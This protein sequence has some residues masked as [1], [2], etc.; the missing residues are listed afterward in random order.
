MARD[1]KQRL[2]FFIRVCM[3]IVILIAA[4]IVYPI[5]I[6]G[7]SCKPKP[8]ITNFIKILKEPQFYL[9]FC[10]NHCVLWFIYLRCTPLPILFM[11]IFKVDAK[12]YGW[13]FAFMSLGF[14]EVPSIEFVA[15]KKVQWVNKWF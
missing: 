10:R 12:T 14:I 3:G 1:Y 8:I 7:H 5:L 9:L 13:I 11:D 2:Y 4:Q 15:I 6:A